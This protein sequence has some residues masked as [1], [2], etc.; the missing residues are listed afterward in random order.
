MVDSISGSVAPS[1]TLLRF[2]LMCVQDRHYVGGKEIQATYA[3]QGRKRPDDFRRMGVPTRGE[4]LFF[5][6]LKTVLQG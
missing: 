5:T 1:L 6:R 2:L 3:Q 4:Q